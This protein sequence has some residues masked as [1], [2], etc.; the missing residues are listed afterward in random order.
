MDE[1]D[2]HESHRAETVEADVERRSPHPLLIEKAPISALPPDRATDARTGVRMPGQLVSS[3]GIVWVRAS[4]LL[5][6]GSGRIAGR[7]IDFEAELSRRMRRTPATTRRAIRERADRLPPL[8]E[9]GSVGDH[10]QFSRYGL[11]RS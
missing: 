3:P 2:S 4:D 6:S 11:G 10:P 5:N 1:E 8:S 7:G 9:F